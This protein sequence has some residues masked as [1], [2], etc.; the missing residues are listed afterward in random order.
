[1]YSKEVNIYAIILSLRIAKAMHMR[2]QSITL[3]ILTMI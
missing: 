3:L 1:M 2:I